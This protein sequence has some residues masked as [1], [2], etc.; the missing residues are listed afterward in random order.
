M[1]PANT[2][3]YAAHSDAVDDA[4]AWC[5]AQGFTPGDVQLVKRD[6]QCLVIAKRPVSPKPGF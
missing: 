3:I 2:V 5:R 6:D 4:K 1:I